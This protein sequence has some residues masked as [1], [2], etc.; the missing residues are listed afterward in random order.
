MYYIL[1]KDNNVVEVEDKEVWAEWVDKSGEEIMR[2]TEVNGAKV[3]TVFMGIGGS[4]HADE[5]PAL[6]DTVV[7]GGE[8]NGHQDRCSIHAEA[9]IAHDRLVDMVKKVRI[10]D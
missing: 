4:F 5:L 2:K 9:M 10:K 3:V 8:Y 1:D 6:F 7:V